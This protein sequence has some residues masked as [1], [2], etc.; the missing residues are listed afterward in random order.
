MDTNKKLIEA[1]QNLMG[2]Y[3]TPIERRHRGDD[4][5]YKEAMKIARQA[6]NDAENTNTEK[7][8]Y[9]LNPLH[10][11]KCMV[12]VSET[13]IINQMD[14]KTKLAFIINMGDNAKHGEN[15]KDVQELA[16]ETFKWWNPG[17]TD[18]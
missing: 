11:L 8:V 9:F 2:L 4:G 10:R 16:N 5:F 6:L 14:N 17:Y 13:D 1:L 3:D 7:P 18:T 12:H 15:R